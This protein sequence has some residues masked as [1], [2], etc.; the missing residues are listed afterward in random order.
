[1]ALLRFL[2][3][4]IVFV[5][6]A[7]AQSEC[8]ESDLGYA[9]MKTLS[10]FYN[11]H[12]TLNEDNVEI[13]MEG[14]GAEWV[15]FSFAEE[16]GAM[17]PADAVIGWTMGREFSVEPYRITERAVAEDNQDEDVTIN[18]RSVTQDD[19]RT[20]VAFVRSLTDGT[21]EIDPEAETL[22]NYAI[23]DMD[24]LVYHGPNRGQSTVTLSL[25]AGTANDAAGPADGPAPEQPLEDDL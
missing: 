2:V 24:S 15:G 17:A 5:A 1:M 7:T 9:C 23:G 12:W 22:I 20:I 4:L 3:V 19:E 13:A 18:G 11:L 14:I 10:D 8:E 25:G 6:S 16:E 21:V